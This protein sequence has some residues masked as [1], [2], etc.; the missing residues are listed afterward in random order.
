MSERE[1]YPADWLDETCP[2]S[3]PRP[4]DFVLHDGEGYR[5]GYDAADGDVFDGEREA[6][7]QEIAIG[8][9]INFMC[10]DRFDDV[11]VTVRRDRRFD[12]HG[13]I[14]PEHNWV[15]VQGDVDTLHDSFAELIEAIFDPHD[16]LHDYVFHDGNDEQRITLAFAR[17]SDLLP[18]KLSIENGK[19]VLRRVPREQ[20]NN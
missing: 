18:H 13:E 12:V 4:E 16:D 11:E 19:P 20:A 7:N 10:C 15:A 3:K 8:D 14:P 1:W 17:W 5:L 2:P 9:I 6:F